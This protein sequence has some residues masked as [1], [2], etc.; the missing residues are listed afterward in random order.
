MEEPLGFR[1]AHLN[2]KLNIQY[3]YWSQ[4]KKNFESM[5]LRV[6]FADQTIPL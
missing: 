4:P 1:L 2:S 6:Q 5:Y 3:R